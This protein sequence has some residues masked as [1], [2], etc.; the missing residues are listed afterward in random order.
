MNNLNEDKELLKKICSELENDRPL[1]EERK[2][3]LVRIIND[4]EDRFNDNVT[5]DN[6]FIELKDK[7]KNIEIGGSETNIKKIMLDLIKGL[8]NLLTLFPW[9]QI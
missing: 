4:L 9:V 1:T 8:I 5:K 7:L 3:E 6:T 2:A